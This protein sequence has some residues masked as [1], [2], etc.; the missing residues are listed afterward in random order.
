MNATAATTFGVWIFGDRTR[1]RCGAVLVLLGL[2]VAGCTS[3]APHF[4]HPRLSVAGLEAKGISLTEQRFRVQMRVQ[5][6]NGIALP[7]RSITCRI[8]LEGDAVGE[9]TSSTPFTVPAHGA[10]DFDLDLR[11]SLA[12]TVLRLL[13]HLHDSSY[14]LHY[15]LVGTV[16]T[17]LPFAG[18]IPFEE[19]GE[20]PV[21]R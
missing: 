7:V 6:P 2:L 15:R 8:E 12:S 1:A 11:T 10:G 21:G 5:N 13:P 9:A 3:L 16:A 18:K 19:K 14:P 17:D 4:E 20:L